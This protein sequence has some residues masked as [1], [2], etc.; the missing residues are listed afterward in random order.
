M[1]FEQ[2]DSGKDVHWGSRI[3]LFYY[4]RESSFTLGER[5]LFLGQPNNLTT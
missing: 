3:E 2:A 1:Q 5:A 4:G